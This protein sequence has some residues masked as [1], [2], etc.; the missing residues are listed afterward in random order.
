MNKKAIVAVGAAAVL[1]AGALVPVT[2][3]SAANGNRGKLCKHDRFF[4]V[5]QGDT[6]NGYAI[7]QGQYKTY[8]RKVPCS[9]AII[10]LHN[11]LGTGETL[12]NWDVMQGGRGV[13]SIKFYDMDAKNTFFE[14]KRVKNQP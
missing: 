1:T 5:H 2:S 4:T 14:I 3:A 11:W 6:V 9:S 8:V 10:D 13:R 7:P 12:S